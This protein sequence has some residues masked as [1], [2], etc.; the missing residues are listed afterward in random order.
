MNLAKLMKQA[1]EM[2]AQMS[3]VQAT[4]AEKTVAVAAGGGKIKV[5]ANGAGD[6]LSIKIDPKAVDPNNIESL[7][8]IVLSGVQQA[9]AQGKTLAQSEVKKITG[10]LK[11]PGF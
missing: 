5:T 1:G 10:G 7:E 9:I 3:K 11:L 4:L 6:V 2:Q 8:K